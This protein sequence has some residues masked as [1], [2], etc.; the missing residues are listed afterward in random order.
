MSKVRN[1]N[2]SQIC[3]SSEALAP[4]PDPIRYST[5]S[6]NFERRRNSALEIDT[7]TAHLG[8]LDGRPALGVFALPT[9]QLTP[10][11]PLNLQTVASGIEAA[12]SPGDDVQLTLP[13][14]GIRGG[15]TT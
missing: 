4:H 12:A 10:P 1:S 13:F 15:D 9:V 2:S 8:D 3:L 11:L 5:S 7:P 6:R 14:I